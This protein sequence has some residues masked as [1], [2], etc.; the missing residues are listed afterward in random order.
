MNRT[1]LVRFSGLSRTALLAGLL[2]LLNSMASAQPNSTQPTRSTDLSKPLAVSVGRSTVL[3]AP[4]P[5]KRVS[6]TDPKIADIQVLT[7]RQ[8]LVSGKAVGSTDIILWNGEEEVQQAQLEITVDRTAIRSELSRLFPKASLDLRQS[9]DV[10]IVSGTLSEAEEAKRLHKYLDAAGLK[11]VDMTSLAGLQQVQLKVMVAEANRTAVRQLG[12]NLYYAGTQFAGGAT[13]GPDVGGLLQAAT[14]FPGAPI[15]AGSI[16]SATTLF[17]SLPT[18]DLALFV[19]ALAENQY[20]RVLAEPTLVAMSGEEASFLAGGEFPI[21]VVQGAG[22][23]T[24]GTSI[25]ITYKEFGVRLRFRP[26]VLGEGLIQLNVAPEVSELTNGGSITLQGFNVP[27]LLT[28]KAETT[29]RLHSGQTFGMAGLISKNTLARSSRIPGLGDLPVV[30]AL[31]RSVR[32]QQGDTELVILVTA[33]LVEPMSV[34]GNA[35]PYPG[36]L[37]VYPNDWDFYA[38]GRVEGSAPPKVSES[39]QKWLKETGLSR[40]RGPGAW[41]TYDT[42]SAASRADARA[43]A[44]TTQRSMT[45]PQ[46]DPTAPRP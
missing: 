25:S 36:K 9:R 26:S 24:N 40:L 38:L 11:Y 46:G 14:V 29:L 44:P 17:G 41:T 22:A 37:H 45:E 15:T 3:Q 6:V 1:G 2:A 34:A 8:V 28:R 23:S 10:V 4:W 21:P 42:I 7:P 33:S 19:Q 31:F 27:G 20:M 39:D 35:V 5:V 32:Y 30:G 13:V 12:V 43:V 18:Q 16:N